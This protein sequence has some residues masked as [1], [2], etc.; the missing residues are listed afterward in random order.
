V[1]DIVS[2]GKIMLQGAFSLLPERMSTFAHYTDELFMFI[3]VLCLI[4]FVGITLTMVAFVVKYRKRSDDDVTPVIK[5]NHTLEI[6]WSVIPGL[7]FV[8]IFAWG[9]IGWSQLNV[10]PPDAI[11]VRVTGLKWAWTFTYPQGFTSGDL[12]VP[13]NKPVKL[14]MS[15]KD[16]IHSFFIP[17]FRIKRDVLPGR[18]TVLWFE[19]L[20][21]GEFFVLCTEYCGTSHS[22]MMAKVKVLPQAEY[23]EW[24]ASGGGMGDDV[25]L[26]QLGEL[27]YQQR[28]CVACHSVDG[29]RMIGPSLKG[30]FGVERAFTDGSKVVGDD[31]Y[32]R[33]SIVNPGVKIVS[34][35]DPV[36]PSFQGQFNDKQLDALV[37]YIKS[38]GQ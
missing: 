7:L 2:Q 35:Y 26:A 5:G 37:E 10:V 12:V 11:N 24:I 33:T 17:E 15:S 29:S 34:G 18:Y 30:I 38:L 25:P 3:T 20:G 13:A 36:M 19:S 16:V 8:G 4:F 14:T 6:V 23:D 22:R 27:L 21:P 31:N 28:G 1:S 32:I 9:F